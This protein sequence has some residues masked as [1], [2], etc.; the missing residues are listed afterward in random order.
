[1]SQTSDLNLRPGRPLLAPGSNDVET[2]I[3]SSGGMYQGGDPLL[4]AAMSTRILDNP[5]TG[6]IADLVVGDTLEVLLTLMGHR[7]YV[8][9]VT[10]SP[11][12]VRLGGPVRPPEPGAE[13]GRLTARPS[14][15]THALRFLAVGEGSGRLTFSLA[16]E[17]ADAS[18]ERID[19]TVTVLPAL[20]RAT[21]PR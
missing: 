13:P 10:D 20:G 11:A 16:T 17:W 5:R 9:A 18:H 3:E 12:V 6:T 8:W 7:G 2:P 15:R 4:L 1:V 19:V 14:T 21:R